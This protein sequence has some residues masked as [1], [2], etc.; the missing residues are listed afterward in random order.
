MSELPTP[1]RDVVGVM[2]HLASAD[3]DAGVHGD[4]N[5]AF[6]SGFTGSDPVSDAPPREQRR[7]R[8]ASPPLASTR[9]AAASRST[10]CRRSAPIPP[11]T[12][13]SPRF[14]GSPGSRRS[15]SSARATPPATVVVSSPTAETW[16]GIV[17]VGYADGFR[18]DLSGTV[19]AVD[20][21]PRQAVGTI[22]MDAFAVELAAAA[23][24]WDASD[25]DRAW[26][27][28][29]GTR[30]CRRDDLLRARH[31]HR[32]LGR[33][34]APDGHRCLTSPAR[35]SQERRPG[36]SAA[37]FATSCSADPLNDLD[38]A[39][40]EPER[41]ARSYARRSGGAPFPLSERH[42]AWRV[43]LDDGRT[44]DFTPLRDGHR[45][46]PG[47]AGLRAERDR[48]AGRRRRAHRSVRRAGAISRR[49]RSGSCGTR[50]SRTIRCACSGQCGSRTSSASGSTRERSGCFARAAERVA[51]PA[52]E[53]ILGELVRL[54][55]D[56]YRRL[57]ELGLLAPLG[58]S[59]DGP[60]DARDEPDFRLVASSERASSGCRSRTTSGAT[61]ALSCARRRPAD[62]SPRAVHRFRRA[63]EPWALDALAFVGAEEFAAAVLAAR[64]GDPATPLVRGD[65]LGLPPGPQIGQVLEA[66]EEER[67]AGT[68]A[69]AGGGVRTRSPLDRVP[70]GGIMAGME[71]IYTVPGMSCGHCTSAVEQ[72]L[73]R[74]AGVETV[75][76]DLETKLVDRPRHRASPT[77]TCAR[78]STR[79]A[80]TSSP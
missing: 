14:G 32:P 13:S 25:A 18:R 17:P 56:G 27:T 31:G 51:D 45:G 16:I 9:P 5:R 2:S 1:G 6:C 24:G 3:C 15:S 29:G 63:T 8:F 72:E 46:R 28:G 21:E 77:P 19:V 66:I 76:V 30:S 11:T 58:G 20:G 73:T 35:C 42:G 54:S 65:E 80:T 4:P 52:G 61:V 22:S 49:A 75:D 40:R 36:S 71:L 64:A 38:I 12:V 79:R 7:R 43:A 69:H 44:V 47:N 67:A 10:G 68:I 48:R 74:V 39:C 50:S 60:L 34:C 59:L 57:D 41:S 26:R 70:L 33:A 23:P 78:R 55:A 37:R 53:R 62:D